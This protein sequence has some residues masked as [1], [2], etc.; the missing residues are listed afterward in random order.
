LKSVTSGA[1]FVTA[2]SHITVA[3]DASVGE[4]TKISPN[5]CWTKCYSAEHDDY[6]YY[7]TST[8]ESAWE[9][10]EG[11]ESVQI[12]SIFLEEVDSSSRGDAEKQLQTSDDNSSGKAMGVSP[13]HYE[14]YA[15]NID[16][17][18]SDHRT[19][20]NASIETKSNTHGLPREVLAEATPVTAFAIAVGAIVDSRTVSRDDQSCD[21]EDLGTLALRRSFMSSGANSVEESPLGSGDE[22]DDDTTPDPDMVRRL[23]EMGFN[24]TAVVKALVFT[25]NNITAAASYLLARKDSARLRAPPTA[26]PRREGSATADLLRRMGGRQAFSP[27]A[28]PSPAYNGQYNR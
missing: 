17:F 16:T 11:V 3:G 27:T 1:S 18:T 2:N 14:G 19:G 6:F 12:D 9:L 15:S 22:N 23:T 5:K 25:E 21:N 26:P 20:K 24:R 13:T 8:N 10:P 7:N 4:S 28:P